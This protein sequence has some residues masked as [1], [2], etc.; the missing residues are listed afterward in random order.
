MLYSIWESIITVFATLLRFLNRWK[1]PTRVVSQAPPNPY[2]FGTREWSEYAAAQATDHELM[3]LR[4]ADLEAQVQQTSELVESLEALSSHQEATIRDLRFQNKTLRDGPDPE[5]FERIWEDLH[6][7][8]KRPAQP[9]GPEPENVG[10]SSAPVASVAESARPSGGGPAPSGTAASQRSV[11][12]SRP[13]T[14][15]EELEGKLDEEEGDS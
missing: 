2:P 12:H 7:P 1:T 5:V 6:K 11:I 8:L 3:V 15:A 4:I 13:L 14:L 10:R 9:E